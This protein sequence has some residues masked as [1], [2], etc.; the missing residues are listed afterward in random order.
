MANQEVLEPLTQSSNHPPGLALL[1][2]T[3]FDTSQAM[4]R[5]R[6]VSYC[7]SGHREIICDQD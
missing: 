1:L 3:H 5:V 2:S 4:C 6:V 7:P